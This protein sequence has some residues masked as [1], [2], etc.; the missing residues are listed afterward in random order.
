MGAADTDGDGL[1]DTEE[2]FY[3]SNPRKS[4]TDGDGFTDGAEVEK[5]YS[6]TGPGK[7]FDV[8]L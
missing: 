2:T 8:P 7:L 4:D 1:S 5:G 3:G 6:P